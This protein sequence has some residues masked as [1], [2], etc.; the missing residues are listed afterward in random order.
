MK[1]L[2]GGGVRCGKSAFALSRARALGPRRV[3][4]ATAEALDGEMTARIAAH[5]RE[6]NDAF[7]TVEA[8][9]QV[10]AAL[11]AVADAEV[12]VLDCLTLWL[13]NLLLRGHSEATMLAEVDRLAT[14]L[15]AKPFHS[16]VVTNEVGMGVVPDSP[17]GRAF[18]DL[19]GRAHQVLAAAMDE[20]Y[21]GA[22][23]LMLR[24][25]PGPVAAVGPME[26]TR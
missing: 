3:Y 9:I 19:S 11:D 13:S 8:P 15:A 18:R 4:I 24:L 23:G 12:V 21:Y 20:V 5:V 16:I 14:V 10:V 22:M 6:R 7:R 1:I 17:M 25:K 26:A 2:I